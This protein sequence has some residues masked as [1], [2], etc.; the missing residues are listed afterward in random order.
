MKK[1]LYTLLL[2][3]LVVIAACR[4]SDNATMP[5]G[6]VY[7]NQPHITKIS[8]S[9][10]IVDIDPMSFSAKVGVD[11]Y[12]K[13]SSKPDKLDLVVVKNGDAKNAKILKAD[14]KTYPIEFDVTGQLLTNLFGTIAS[15][16]RF[17]IGADYYLNGIKYPAFPEGGANPYG[18]GVNSQSGSS[19]TVR[20]T[21]I[22]GFD[23]DDFIGDGKF[24]LT[25]DDWGDFGVGTELKVKKVDGS[26]LAIE[27]LGYPFS[28]IIVDINIDDNTANVASQGIG[29][30]SA[31]G[32]NY[33][34]LFIKSDGGG[35]Y[36][37]INPCNKSI[38]LFIDYRVSLGGFGSYALVLKKKN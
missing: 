4:K 11:L 27:Y 31:Y 26:K 29:N 34:T 15:G 2:I 12:F 19:P 6:I 21:A 32:L 38:N 14:I 5:D 35:N 8:G 23:M 3:S 25:V 10:A 9:A 30:T 1:I 33:G 37:Y 13:N 24:E 22:C 17:D 7:L 28:D 18:S 20:Y 36:N 16:D